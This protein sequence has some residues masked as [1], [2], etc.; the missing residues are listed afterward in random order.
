MLIEQDTLAK[1]YD[2]YSTKTGHKVQTDEYKTMLQKLKQTILQINCIL[3][4][5]LKINILHIEIYQPIK[6]VANFDVTNCL[7]RIFG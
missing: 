1:I 4:I 5:K 2:L 6:S 3:I 7:Q